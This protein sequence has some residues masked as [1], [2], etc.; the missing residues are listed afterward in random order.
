MMEFA[1]LTVASFIAPLLSCHLLDGIQWL[2]SL[3]E[4]SVDKARGVPISGLDAVAATDGLLPVLISP[5]LAPTPS[6]VSFRDAGAIPG[7]RQRPSRGPL[8]D[9]EALAWT[10]AHVCRIILLDLRL[11]RERGRAPDQLPDA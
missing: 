5:P 10:A 1:A 2:F 9:P 7:P 11:A 8:E 3:S 4:S 6:L